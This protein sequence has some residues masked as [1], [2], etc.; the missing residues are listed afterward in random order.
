V[1]ILN[2]TQR[3]YRLSPL[4]YLPTLP[5]ERTAVFRVRMGF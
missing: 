2:L 4:T 1:G 3:E 5:R